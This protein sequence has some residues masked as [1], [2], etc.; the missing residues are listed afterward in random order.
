[1]IVTKLL[2]QGG[3][4]RIRLCPASG[5]NRYGCKVVPETGAANFASTTAS[6]ISQAAVDH[7][8]AWLG[9]LR[10]DGHSQ[11]I[12]RDAAQQTRE[13]LARLCGLPL[14]S[15]ERIVLAPSGT[16]LHLIV[17]ELA[18]GDEAEP[19]AVAMP[20]PSETG[21]GVPF[22][23]GRRRFGVETAHG[24]PVEIG[25]LLP[26]AIA[27]ETAAIPLRERDGTPRPSTDVD[28][29]FERACSPW[30][31]AGR[32]VLL[33]LVDASKTGLL[34]PSP[35]WALDLKR[36]YGEQL[37][38]LVDACQ[39]RLSTE[40]LATYLAADF[41]VAVTGSKFVAGPAFS[42]ALI[43]P[44]AS[45]LRLRDR[46]LPIALADYS[47]R[48]D[49][50]RGFLGRDVLPDLPNFGMLARW[51]AALYELEAFRSLPAAEVQD[52]LSRF[53]DQV[54]A[55]LDRIEALERLETPPPARFGVSG[56]DGNQTI[57]TF[58]VV[59]GGRAMSASQL[60]ALYERLRQ[61]PESG[62]MAVRLGQPVTVGWD[63]DQPR[64]ALRISASAPLIVEARGAPDGGDAVI[65]RAIE[66]LE[67]TARAA[68]RPG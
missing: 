6:T 27:G 4:E 45:A 23:V 11:D 29:D 68:R 39:F 63:E 60:H 26:G 36:R 50:P 8:T 33:V 3:D 5:R 64:S 58:Q 21:R 59:D 7:V 56:W 65:A 47:G 67:I 44:K 41:L 37:T 66:A 1:M 62:E 22:A 18:R 16:D 54:G 20:H 12:Y 55:G 10:A 38:V 9:A 40:S 31:A 14:E 13:D 24:G 15:A 52:F 17:A 19:L 34:A 42:G 25:A 57:F 49:W 48:A 30:L 32:R 46:L 35:A 61:T 43:I 28:E 53:A 51:R 2:T